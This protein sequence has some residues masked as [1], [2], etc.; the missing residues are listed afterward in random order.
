MNSDP[1]YQ[2]SVSQ[3]M[4]QLIQRIQQ[5]S[6]LSEQ[7]LNARRDLLGLNHNTG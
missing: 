5:V 1:S 2:L 7:L 3:V 6:N 4:G